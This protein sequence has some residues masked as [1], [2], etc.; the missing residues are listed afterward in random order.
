VPAYTRPMR[1]VLCAA[2][3]VTAAACGGPDE[4]AGSQLVAEMRDHSFEL[5]SSSVSA[6]RVSIGVR[7]RGATAHDLVV[8]RT[9]RPADGL[10]VAGLKAVEEGRVGAIDQV[11]PGR[12][13][14]LEVDLQAGR[15]LLICNVPTHYGF[16]MRSVL[17][18]R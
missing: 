6:G 8:L 18:V 1:I 16:G 2:L 11:P 4:A 14:K 17:T 10:E 9:D 13:R 7:N 12:S 15:Y 3:V 5:S